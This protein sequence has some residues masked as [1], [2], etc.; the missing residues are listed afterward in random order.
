MIAHSTKK[1]WCK[2]IIRVNR[3]F[4]FANSNNNNARIQITFICGSK[5]GRLK[6]LFYF[7]KLAKLFNVIIFRMILFYNESC[8][9]V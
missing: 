6:E 1:V 9:K 8:N 7:N 4:S 5:C 3:V 2:L